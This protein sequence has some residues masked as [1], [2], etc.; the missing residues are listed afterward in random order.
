MCLNCGCGEPEA[1][2]DSPANITQ[3]DLVRA[4]EAN[5]QTLEE[6]VANLES[7]L[8]QLTGQEQGSAAASGS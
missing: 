3:S 8:G 7:A 4:G 5:G 2:H 6:T 1:R